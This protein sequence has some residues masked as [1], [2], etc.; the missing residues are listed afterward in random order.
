M[1]MKSRLA[2]GG[3]VC[4][5]ASDQLERDGTRQRQLLGAVDHAHPT[6]ADL[7]ID[8]KAAEAG[9]DAFVVH[10]TRRC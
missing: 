10:H 7:R 9:A 4:D 2:K 1:A 8:A 6:L 3:V 5:L